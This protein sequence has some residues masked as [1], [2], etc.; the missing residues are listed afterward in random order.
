MK[1]KLTIRYIL[2][3]G[4]VSISIII[5]DILAAIILLY[6]GNAISGTSQE[7]ENYVRNFSAYISL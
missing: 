2:S 4:V 6:T 7:V 5:L 1:S 3:V